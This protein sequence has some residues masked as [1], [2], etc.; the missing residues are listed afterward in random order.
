[1]FSRILATVAFAASTA[2]PAW[3][4]DTAAKPAAAPAQDT[5]AQAHE[6]VKNKVDKAMYTLAGSGLK[7]ATMQTDMTIPMMGDTAIKCKY[8]WQADPPREKFMLLDADK[9]PQ[10]ISMMKQMFEDNLRDISRSFIETYSQRWKDLKLS[11]GKTDDGNVSITL[12]EKKQSMGPMT[13][14]RLETHVFSPEGKL[15]RTETKMSIPTQGERQQKA[16]VNTKDVGGKWL[17]T[18][19]ED[20]SPQGA[21]KTEISY[22][23]KDG[24]QV[25]VQSKQ[26]TQMG[27][28]VVKF[29]F[30]INPKLTDADFADA[31]APKK[32]G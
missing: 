16:T 28:Q 30:T 19:R 20:N 11:M 18:G 6:F 27:D 8:V 21:V 23:E 2:L 14:T 22:E 17:M 1:M 13:M 32:E 29:T 25:P 24:F 5:D 26:T 31:A 15:L 12:P 9:L 7:S 3:C 4:Q 10:Q